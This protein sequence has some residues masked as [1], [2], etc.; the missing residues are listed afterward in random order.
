MLLWRLLLTKTLE[1]LHKD[2]SFNCF[3]S[4]QIWF[5]SDTGERSEE[6]GTES[7][8]P[9][10]ERSFWNPSP[11]RVK[12]KSVTYEYNDLCKQKLVIV[13]TLRIGCNFNLNI[14]YISFPLS[15]RSLS[16]IQRQYGH[17]IM[18]MISALKFSF[19]T[20]T[21][22]PVYYQPSRY[23]KLPQCLYLWATLGENCPVRVQRDCNR[24]NKRRKLR[25]Y[26]F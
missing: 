3:S 2:L 5:S 16:A 23:S 17:F 25:W 4:H 18:N 12:K 22:S 24:E 13:L 1:I 14:F 6:G 11:G 9:H 7:A 26:W 19:F 20:I 10:S 15:H 8:P 21:R